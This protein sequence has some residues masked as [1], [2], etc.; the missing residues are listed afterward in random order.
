MNL[1][2]WFLVR[3]HVFQK[4]N[5]PDMIK[6]QLIRIEFAANF[7]KNKQKMDGKFKT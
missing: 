3:F 5:L 4:V 2:E 1:I 7:L 6:N